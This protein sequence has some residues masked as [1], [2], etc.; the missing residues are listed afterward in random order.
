MLWCLSTVVCSRVPQLEMYVVLFISLECLFCFVCLKTLPAH[1]NDIEIPPDL[2]EALLSGDGIEF[3]GDGSVEI[4]DDVDPNKSSVISSMLY[5]SYYSARS[6]RQ[7]FMDESEAMQELRK[8]HAD[9]GL[10]LYPSWELRVVGGSYGVTSHE[11]P[12][13]QVP[14]KKE[15]AAPTPAEQA[16]TG[17]GDDDDGDNDVEDD[18]EDGRSNRLDHS[19]HPSTRATVAKQRGI[20]RTDM[21]TVVNTGMGFKF[22][23][24]VKYFR[25]T[26]KLVCAGVP[27]EREILKNLNL[28]LES[29]KLYLILG[30][31]G[32]GKSTVLKYVANLLMEDKD[33]IRG[34][35][36]TLNG[37]DPHNPS[38]EWTNLVAY[39]D[40]I[41]RN[42]EY[43][44][45]KETLNY[46][47]QCRRAGTHQDPAT[48]SDD[49]QARQDQIKK[50]DDDNFLVTLVMK[51]LGLTRVE[52]TFV[53]DDER[54]RGVSGGERKRVT[55]AEMSVMGSPV[56]CMDEIS[57]GLDAATTYDICKTLGDAC[58]FSNNI[59]VISLLQPPPETVALFDELILVDQGEVVYGGPLLEAVPHF[60]SLGYVLPD[61]IDAADWLLALSTPEGAKFLR[62]EAEDEDKDDSHKDGGSSVVVGKHL[63]HDDFV[64]AY[65]ASSQAQTIVAANNT[66]LDEE[67]SSVVDAPELTNR[68]ANS[69]SR[70]LKLVI[71]HEFLLWRRDSL[72]L[73]A[74]IVQGII[75]GLVV[76]TVFYQQADDPNAGVGVIY[77][78]L[79]FMSLGGL[80]KVAPQVDCRSIFYKHQ[81][82]NFFPTSAFVIGRSIANIP[83][84]LLDALFF[85]VPVFFLSGMAYTDGASMV[86]FFMF[87]LTILVAA[88]TTFMT[89]TILSA[90]LPDK[91]SAIGV[92][93]AILLFMVVFSG[94]TVQPD[95]IPSYWIWLYWLNYFA[96]MLRALIINQYQSGYAAFEVVVDP[97]TGWTVGDT[98]MEA[99][100][101]VDAQG[102]P[103]G[104]E[105]VWWGILF[106]CAMCVLAAALNIA[107]LNR[108]RFATGQSLQA[109]EDEN[110]TGDK[111]NNQKEVED[112]PFQKANLTF[113]GISYTVKSSIS[114]ESIELLKGVDGYFAAG[115][116]T[117]LMGSSGAGKTTLMDVLA[118]RK[119]SG[120]I[121]GEVRLNGHL[122]DPNSFRRCTGYVEQ[123]D[124]Q[125]EQLTVRE[126]IEFS[127]KMRLDRKGG[128]LTKE[129]IQEFANATLST[130]ELDPISDFLVGSDSQGGLSFEQ[131][132]R[133]SI[134]VEVAS[135]PS[136][137]FLDEP[138]SGLDARSASIVMRGL[139]RI[140]ESGRA[141]CA[142]I[143]QPSVAIFNSFDMLLLLKRGGETVFFG[144]LG[145][146]SSR[147]IDY[148]QRFDTTPPIRPGENPATWML[149]TIGS[150]TNASDA[151]KS[152]DFAKA[153][154]NSKLHA[155]GLTTID[156]FESEAV[157]SNLIAFD[158]TYATGIKYQMWQV[159][160]R[161]FRVYWRSPSYNRNRMLLAALIGLLFGSVFASQRVPTNEV[162]KRKSEPCSDIYRVSTP[163]CTSCF[164]YCYCKLSSI[165]ILVYPPFVVVVR[166]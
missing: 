6:E 4:E 9:L 146:E 44:T 17:D 72:R 104:Y 159:F 14:P 129:R 102:N 90:S 56:H 51:A 91:P 75:M 61:R 62:R 86:N 134:A 3:T 45:V 100:G 58:R 83:S 163:H 65:M 31:P 116:M 162:R 112:L 114:K 110:D 89:F 55:V 27:R 66:P 50:M 49:N 141:V 165:L 36:V 85:S 67:V 25:Q 11:M 68:Y 21:P 52:N 166:P 32:S 148:F 39:T 115:K 42:H 29:G 74:R 5:E 140:A 101:F 33:H 119:Q 8:A 103:Y 122:Q 76:G 107:C 121:E 64:R 35:T 99:F 139:K 24:R 149:T 133:L 109:A 41:D 127:A 53:G 128:K 137:L 48:R 143:H 144:E 132:K 88:Y 113:K 18:V 87:L 40:Q 73:K 22:M 145:E 120:V 7:Q 93:V 153:Y 15:K 154:A 96:W 106:S 28:R 79:F 158:T 30:L 26:G 20:F 161:Q 63:S 117:A 2:K 69:W 94:F 97:A 82:A 151:S 34:G 136:I 156:D 13:V 105:W 124:V 38:F 78:S 19:A 47:F 138:T 54:V 10:K 135:N 16:K 80:T 155:E 43:M 37:V 81:D 111:H 92:A 160:Q 123:F 152:M 46:A 71:Q 12:H 164:C 131:K 1:R 95:V 147:L 57:T 77:Q 70:S 130:L 108:I 59:R 84:S 118:L 98:Y 157:D 60:E 125:S 150:G 142:T 23:Q 126:T